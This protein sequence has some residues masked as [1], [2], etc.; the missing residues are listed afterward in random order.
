[1]AD[2]V[3]LNVGLIGSGIRSSRSPQLHMDEARALGLDL[4]YTLFDLK[5]QVDGLQALERVLREAEAMGFLGVNVTHP[6]KQAVIPL[7][8]EL[9]ESAQALGAVNT[10]AFSS[11]RRIGHNTDWSGFCEGFRIGLPD[12]ALGRV[13]LVGAGGA[14]SAVAYAM[15]EMGAEQIIVFDLDSRKAGQTIALLGQKFSPGRMQL[16]TDLAAAIAGSDGIINTTPMGMATHPGLPVPREL[17]R[18]SLWVAEVVYF[19]LVTALLQAASDIGCRTIDGGGMVVFQ[20]AAAF[21]IFTGKEPDARRML[22]RFREAT[23]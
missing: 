7:L 23:P 18:P 3:Q 11:G 20:A 8:H 13:T 15:L 14:G 9:S 2:P 12:A 17:L 4:N 6:V 5:E 19:P 22:K 21:R 10:V 1:M 16:G